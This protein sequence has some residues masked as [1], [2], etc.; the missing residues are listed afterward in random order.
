MTAERVW[1]VETAEIAG[2]LLEASPAAALAF[3]LLV[4]D[5][6]K[7]FAFAIL[8]LRLLLAGVFLHGRYCGAAAAGFFFATLAPPSFAM[9]FD[10][11]LLRAAPA[12]F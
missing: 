2:L 12:S 9:H 7:A 6:E 3:H 4:A 5:L 10:M 1:E 11:K 8:A